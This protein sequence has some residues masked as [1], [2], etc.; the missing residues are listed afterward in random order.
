[1]AFLERGEVGVAQWTAGCSARHRPT[2]EE[3][4]G[5][6]CADGSYTRRTRYLLGFAIVVGVKMK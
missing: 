1:M 2:F 6:A 4:E 5:K 3:D